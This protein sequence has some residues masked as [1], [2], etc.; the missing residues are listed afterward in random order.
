MV[1][2]VFF[3]VIMILQLGIKMT[4]LL[5]IYMRARLIINMEIFVLNLSFI[6]PIR[7][8]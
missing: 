6:I 2:I 1:S 3:I 7:F 4:V 5:T 8:I